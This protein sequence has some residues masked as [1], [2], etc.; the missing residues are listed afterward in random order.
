M[1]LIHNEGS[2]EADVQAE[3]ELSAMFLL[4]PINKPSPSTCFKRNISNMGKT[5]FAITIYISF[6]NFQQFSLSSLS[7]NPLKRFASCS[8]SSVQVQQLYQ[9][10]QYQEHLSVPLRIP[11][12]CPPPSIW[13]VT[14]TRGIF[15]TNI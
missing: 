6:F 15:T 14:F 8:I 4:K 2:R 11:L 13:A 7:L 9:I 12:S 5:M 10:Q 3:P 1:L